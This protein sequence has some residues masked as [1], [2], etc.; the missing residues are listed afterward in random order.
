[1]L[2]IKYFTVIHIRLTIVKKKQLWISSV[3]LSIILTVPLNTDFARSEVDG[4]LSWMEIQ[5]LNISISVLWW[6]HKLSDIR[7]AYRDRSNFLRPTWLVMTGTSR[8][9]LVSTQA[10]SVLTL[11]SFPPIL[12]LKQPV[13][14]QTPVVTSALRVQMLD[15]SA[16]DSSSNTSIP[17]SSISIGDGT[18]VGITGRV[19]LS[20]S[21]SSVM[22]ASQRSSDLFCANTMTQA[23]ASAAAR[24]CKQVRFSLIWFQEILYSCD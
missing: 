5:L 21:S 19:R 24:E 8:S 15:D 4:E 16:S 7:P 2:D 18:S 10:A 22:S 9:R 11:L 1:M 17:A 12:S 23:N 14:L 3:F 6:N 13:I 20:S